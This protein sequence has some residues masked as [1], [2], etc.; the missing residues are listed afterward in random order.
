[1]PHKKPKLVNVKLWVS[2][3][4]VS[5]RIRLFIRISIYF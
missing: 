5:F 1:M 3:I 4:K 2:F